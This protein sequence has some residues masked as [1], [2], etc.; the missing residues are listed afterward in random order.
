LSLKFSRNSNWRSAKKIEKKQNG[1]RIS[2]I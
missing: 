2:I 1:F